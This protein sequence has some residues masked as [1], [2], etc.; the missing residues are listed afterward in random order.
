M[1]KSLALALAAGLV[2]AVAA[3]PAAADPKAIMT[4]AGCMACH[5][6]DKKMVGP[7]FQDVAARYKGQNVEAA[8]AG[9]IRKG[10]KGVYGPVPM[11]PNPVSKI[12]DDDIRTVVRYVLALS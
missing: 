3:Q 12:S 5:A 11:P 6:M 1:K 7:S 8:L 10:G 2:M 4:K 9:K